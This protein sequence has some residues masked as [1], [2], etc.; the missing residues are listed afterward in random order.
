MATENKVYVERTFECDA[1]TLFD[2]LTKPELI[3]QWFGPEGFSAGKVVSNPIVG[4]EYSIELSK[5]DL[6]FTVFGRY[7]ELEMSKRVKVTYRYD[8]LERPP[9]TV[10]FDL[11]EKDQQRTALSMVQEFEVEVPD[12]STRSKAWNFMFES[13]ANKI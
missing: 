3:V 11:R 12:M 4:G 2:W 6:S 1:S 8:G 9:S 5:G 13:L 10:L 7:T